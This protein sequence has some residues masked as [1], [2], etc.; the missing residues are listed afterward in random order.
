MFELLLGLEKGLSPAAVQ[1]RYWK[2]YLNLLLKIVYAFMTAGGL[3][4]IPLVPEA[5]SGTHTTH[6]PP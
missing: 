3:A 6:S 2:Q 1:E 5:E 4:E